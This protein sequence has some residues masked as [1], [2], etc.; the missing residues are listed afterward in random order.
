MWVEEDVDYVERACSKISTLPS[1]DTTRDPAKDFRVH[2]PTPIQKVHLEVSVS[3]LHQ[4]NHK[5]IQF[6]MALMQWCVGFM[7]CFG[8]GEMLLGTEPQYC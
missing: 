5:W 6:L 1:I 2:L 7:F 4:F 3:R 8:E